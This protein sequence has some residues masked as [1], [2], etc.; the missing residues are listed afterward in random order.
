MLWGAG[1]RAGLYPLSDTEV[2]WFTTANTPKVWWLRCGAAGVV[3][4]G[5]NL[6]RILQ[7]TWME[8]SFSA[9]E[10]SCVFMLAYLTYLH[11]PMPMSRRLSDPTSC[12]A[13][14]LRCCCRHCLHLPN[15]AMI[16]PTPILQGSQLSEPEACRADALASVANW[17]PEIR[18]A[19]QNTPLDRI[20]RSRITDRC[21]AQPS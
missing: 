15:L 8:R 6:V 11:I 21:M 16:S 2:Y 5:L 1:V 3:F 4:R 14:A 18:D 10:T 7:L 13:A 12:R 19:I 9:E 17:S 20:T